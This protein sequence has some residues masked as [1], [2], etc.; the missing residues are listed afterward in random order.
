MI[1]FAGLFTL[2]VLSGIPIVAGQ[3][4]VQ[5]DWVFPQSPDYS[6]ILSMGS[7]VTFK[8]TTNLKNQFATY[9]PNGNV[10][11]VDIWVTGA[12][13]SKGYHKLA[14]NFDVTSTQSF[15]WTV[16]VPS[17]ELADE[18][19]WS[20]ISDCGQYEERNGFVVIV[21]ELIDFIV[22]DIDVNIIIVI[23]VKLS[24]FN[25]LGQLDNFTYTSG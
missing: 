7:S 12:T 1:T 19:D 16:M 22:I 6:T 17:S 11:H 3:L 4:T 15:Q 21:G 18:A 8:W 9:L 20:S 5:S 14:A 10:S 23:L 2:L 25:D 13:I 24:D